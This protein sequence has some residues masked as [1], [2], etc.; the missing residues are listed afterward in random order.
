MGTGKPA[1]FWSRVMR[2]QVWYADSRH[3]LWRPNVHILS[4]KVVHVIS[5]KLVH[6][7]LDGSQLPTHYASD[8]T[9]MVT[10]HHNYLTYN[11]W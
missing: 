8:M 11:K 3:M 1:V 2:V 6:S 4:H 10:V 5:L 7:R 9:S